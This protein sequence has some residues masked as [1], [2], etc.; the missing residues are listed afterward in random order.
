MPAHP[1]L[2]QLVGIAAIGPRALDGRNIE[3]CVRLGAIFPLSVVAF[4][5]GS[6]FGELT[7]QLGIFRC[8]RSQREP[9][10]LEFARQIRGHLQALEAL[11][12]VDQI[13]VTAVSS[14]LASAAS[15]SVSCVMKFACTQ[16]ARLT[17]S[18]AA[19]GQP[20]FRTV[21]ERLGIR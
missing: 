7:P 1:K 11:G 19:V 20:T 12:L 18:D 4:Q 6:N 21:H 15:T 5:R 8:R 16:S 3:A 14:S 17:N 13:E 2:F 9:Q 10:Q